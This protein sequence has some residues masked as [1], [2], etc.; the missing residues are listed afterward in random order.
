MTFRIDTHPETF[1]LSSGTVTGVISV[2]SDGRA[3]PDAKWDDFIVTIVHWWLLAATALV[4]GENRDGRFS[5]MDG[6]YW[7]EVSLEERPWRLRFIDDHEDQRRPI[8]EGT[9]E[10]QDLIGSLLAVA[11]TIISHCERHG[12]SESAEDFG[13]LIDARAALASAWADQGPR[14]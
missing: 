7:F 12:W 11:D 2:S 13:D 6:P 9:V 5:F 10:P 14:S 8:L 4:R 3:F 1:A